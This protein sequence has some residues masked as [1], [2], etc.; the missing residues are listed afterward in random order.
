MKRKYNIF[1]A[2]YIF[3]MGLKSPR[4]KPA[5]Y[6]TYIFSKISKNQKRKKKKNKEN[7]LQKKKKKI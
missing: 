4:A 2:I 7:L 3:R 6:D 1:I 5:I